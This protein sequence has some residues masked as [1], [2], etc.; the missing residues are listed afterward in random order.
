MKNTTPILLFVTAFIAVFLQALFSGVRGWVGAQIDPMP[1]LMVFAALQTRL[2]TVIL[3]AVCGGL[4]LDSLSANPLGVSVLPLFGVGFVIYLQRE[5]ILRDLTFAQFALG[6]SA[7]LAVPILKL[8][9]LFSMGLSP[10]VGWG[11]VWQLL[12]M[13]AAGGVLAPLFFRYFQMLRQAF[14]HPPVKELGFRPDREIRRG[15]F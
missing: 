4:W 11:T 12:V 5:L 2:R 15:K 3:L 8:L 1:A 9:L 10:L 7:S 6:L 14:F 13:S